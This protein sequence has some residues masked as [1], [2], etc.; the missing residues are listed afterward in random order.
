VPAATPFQPDDLYCVYCHAHADGACATCRAVICADCA[1]LTG[2]T[3]QLAAVCE[4]CA[5]VGRGQVGLL[6][7]TPILLLLAVVLV[8]L[9]GLVG[10]V[11]VAYI[12]SP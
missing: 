10:L 1:V 12:T 9:V 8:G 2:G 3:V 11:S 4:E 7:W 6:Q 5:G